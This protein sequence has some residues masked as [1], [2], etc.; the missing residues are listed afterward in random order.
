MET[1]SFEV[2]SHINALHQA[3][4]ASAYS[5]SNP[6]VLNPFR[7]ENSLHVG[8]LHKLV[9]MCRWAIVYTYRQRN[10]PDNLIHSG[11]SCNVGAAQKVVLWCPSLV[12]KISGLLTS[13]LSFM[14]TKNCSQIMNW[15]S[16][17]PWHACVCM[18][19]CVHVR[20]GPGLMCFRSAVEGI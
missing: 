14:K 3:R 5:P 4:T 8:I 9:P 17:Q 15:P 18:R 10:V 2:P 7:D 13:E 20:A 16:S 11:S 12:L 1:K 19:V 6:L